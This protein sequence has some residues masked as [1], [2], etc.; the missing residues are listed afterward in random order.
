MNPYY[1]D[2][3][4]TIYHGDCRDI[5]PSLPKV[6]LVLTDPPYGISL[7][8]AYRQRGRSCLAQCRNYPPV[9]GDTKPFDPAFILKLNVPTCLF[10]ANYYAEK[11]PHSSGWLVWDKRCGRMQNDQADAELAWTN[12]IKGVRVFH[13]EW[14]GFVKA[15]EHGEGYHPTGKPVQLML[16]ILGL[17]WTPAGTI[18]DPYMGSGGVLRASKDLR[19]KCIGIEIEE[20]Y[21]EIAVKRLRQEVLAL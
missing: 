19:R 7:E 17:R 10:G 11:L 1:Q 21:C 2:D 4:C 12:F 16:W 3:Y 8:T 20:K 13:H 5:M 15:S 14:N 6:D 18:L 9:I